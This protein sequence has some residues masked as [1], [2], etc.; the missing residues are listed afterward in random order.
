LLSFDERQDQEALELKKLRLLKQ[1]LMED[2][3][4]GRVRVRSLEAAA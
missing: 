3:L 1:G 2:L 4:T